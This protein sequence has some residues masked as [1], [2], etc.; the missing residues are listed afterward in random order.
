[1]TSQKPKAWDELAHDYTCGAWFGE[2]IE[3]PTIQ[4]RFR[5]KVK[6]LK[7]L[8]V[9]CGYGKHAKFFADEGASVTGIDIS[10]AMITLAKERAPNATF[11]TTPASDLSVLGTQKFDLIVA[12]FLFPNIKTVDEFYKCC[13]EMRAHLKPSGQLVIYDRHPFAFR[14]TD[15]ELTKLNIPNNAG[16][17]DN[18]C[19]FEVHLR[20]RNEKWI[21][22]NNYHWTMEH[23]HTQLHKAG[24][25]IHSLTEPKPAAF[26]KHYAKE[27]SLFSKQPLHMMLECEGATH[28]QKIPRR[29]S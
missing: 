29:S 16:Y 5:N 7:V 2:Y 13:C 18:G 14:Q 6:D 17:Y 27:F 10:E 12:V 15:T 25:T 8:D 9:A 11:Y 28:G 1:M 19:P 24:F 4:N 23:W 21:Q 20:L 26:P 3:I 22:F